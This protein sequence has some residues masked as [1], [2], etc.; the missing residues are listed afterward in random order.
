MKPFL[1][2]CLVLALA[3]C[4]GPR[5]P[6]PNT[7]E[8]RYDAK[9][10]AVQVM[11]SG[12]R[13]ASGAALISGQG[14]R[15]PASAISVVSGPHVLYN[16]PPSVSLGIGG[17]GFTGC[18]SGF[19]SGLSVGLPVGRP[20]P[21]E[22]SDQ[23]VASALIPVPADYATNWSSYHLQVSIGDQ[24]VTLAAPAPSA[25]P[26]GPRAEN[27]TGV[28]GPCCDVP[29]GLFEGGLHNDLGLT[30]PDVRR[31][32]TPWRSL[33]ANASEANDSTLRRALERWVAGAGARPVRGHVARRRIQG[34]EHDR[35][36]APIWNQTSKEPSARYN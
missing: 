19:G 3:A 10:R 17:F 21:A 1:V 24:F 28:L 12:V 27:G 4:S 9:G 25:L 34:D 36:A 26:S 20:T 11:I 31:E 13:P 16:P 2:T 30:W 35:P 5:L 15:Y 6:S 33:T 7:A 22:V 18:C 32:G 23:Y 29:N 14:L 8:V